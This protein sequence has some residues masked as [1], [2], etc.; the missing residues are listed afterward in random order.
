MVQRAPQDCCRPALAMGVLLALA[1][2]HSD[3]FTNP[4]TGTNQPFDP[5]PPVRLTLNDGPDRDPSWLPD[6][7]GI[8]YQA[9]QLG[10]PDFDACL[11]ELPP[12]G[13]TQRRLV[14]DVAPGD[15]DLT[16]AYVSPVAAPDGRLA[17]LSNRGTIQFLDNPTS[18]SDQ[19]LS[20]AP[21]LDAANAVTVQRLPY[22]L[23]GQRPHNSLSQLQW[24]GSGGLLY[25]AQASDVRRP[26]PELP[27]DTMTTGMAVVTISVTPPG[28]P[29]VVPTPG[30]P[31]GVAAGASTD[32][33][34]FTLNGDSRVF[35]RTLSSG[36][37]TV[38]FDFGPAAV[39]R[40]VQVVGQRMAAVVG[41]RVHVV[42]D[43]TFGEVQR[44]SGGVIHVVDLASGGDAT[45]DREG[46]LFRHPV[47]SPDGE[48]VVAEGYPLVIIANPATETADT[49]VSRRSDLYL[50][51][52]P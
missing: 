38:V 42:P 19:A 41:G 20:V 47:L 15:D 50:F 17:F 28:Q 45:L 33:L 37:E 23:P 18:P 31:S 21:R 44:D 43:P 29:T 11:A 51:S 5:T 24:L 25:L 34:Y 4:S 16:N 48:R 36:D 12:D 40:D 10:Q 32:E 6:G 3:P 14:C 8:L 27:V 2:G 39:A 35:R 52:A 46:L 26:S 9:Q 22:Q 49:T 13:G 7:S 1:C 30:F